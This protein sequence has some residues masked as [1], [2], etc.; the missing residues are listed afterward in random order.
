MEPPPGV[1][2]SAARDIREISGQ[3]SNIAKASAKRSNLHSLN[4]VLS[5]N[6]IVS[7]GESH[8]K[9]RNVS[10]LVKPKKDAQ[11]SAEATETK[12]DQSSLHLYAPEINLALS[13]ADLLSKT[14]SSGPSRLILQGRFGSMEDFIRTASDESRKSSAQFR[15]A[16]SPHVGSLVPT[17]D[18]AAAAIPANPSAKRQRKP[19]AAAAL[20]EK[21]KVPTMIYG[22]YS[23]AVLAL[24][25]PGPASGPTSE[26][27]TAA[28]TLQR[29][30]QKVSHGTRHLYREF[31][32]AR[33]PTQIYAEAIARVVEEADRTNLSATNKGVFPER[34]K[35]TWNYVQEVAYVEAKT[36]EE[37]CSFGS[38]CV[39]FD[40]VMHPE[41]GCFAFRKWIPPHSSR[42]HK[43]C[44]ACIV[45]LVAFSLLVH[46]AT[47]STSS[48][49]PKSYMPF[50]YACNV[51]GEYNEKAFMRDKDGVG[52][53]DRVRI[54]CTTDLMPAEK[55]ADGRRR[56]QE[57][58]VLRYFDGSRRLESLPLINPQSYLSF[59]AKTMSNDRMLMQWLFRDV[60][61][62]LRDVCK[63]EL[64]EW[65]KI[66]RLAFMPFEEALSVLVG[67][68]K[69]PVRPECVEFCRNS[70][71]SD[72]L[73]ERGYLYMYMDL[74]ERC[75]LDKDVV[76]MPVISEGYYVYFLLHIRVNAYMRMLTADG[77]ELLY[78]LILNGVPV[79]GASA[80][81]VDAK[82]RS[83]APLAPE[84]AVAAP[85]PID[86]KVPRP[87]AVSGGS[88]N[89]QRQTLLME[90]EAK[91]VQLETLVR[92]HGKMMNYICAQFSQKVPLVH[93]D[94][95]LSEDV[96]AKIKPS[97]EYIGPFFPEDTRFQE[98]TK[99]MSL[100]YQPGPAQRLAC[101]LRQWCI[102]LLTPGSPPSASARDAA[103]AI[104]DKLRLGE[105]I[106]AWTAEA[107]RDLAQTSALAMTLDVGCVRF[108]YELLFG[109]I[110]AAWW[111]IRS[112]D[113]SEQTLDTLMKACNNFVDTWD[114]GKRY[115]PKVLEAMRQGAS[116]WRKKY[117]LLVTLLL[118]IHCATALCLSLENI[119]TERKRFSSFLEAQ[120]DRRTELFEI[121]A[122]RMASMQS[123]YDY[124]FSPE[125]EALVKRTPALE[126]YRK[127]VTALEEAI[128]CLRR[129]INSHLPMAHAMVVNCTGKDG[130]GPLDSIL[131]DPTVPNCASVNDDR[132]ARP[133]LFELLIPENDN[134]MCEDNL[135]DCAAFEHQLKFIADSDVYEPI[136]AAQQKTAPVRCHT[137]DAAKQSSLMAA[138]NTAFL[139]YCITTLYCTM[140]GYRKST[141][142][143]QFDKSLELYHIFHEHVVSPGPP[144]SRPNYQA[145]LNECKQLSINAIRENTALN[146]SHSIGFYMAIKVC[147]AK[148]G[149]DYS[150]FER[151]WLPNCT[152]E[153]RRMFDQGASLQSIN[154]T[155]R[156]TQTRSRSFVYRRTRTDFFRF[157]WTLLKEV[158]CKRIVSEFMSGTEFEWPNILTMHRDYM[159][160]ILRIVNALD[161]HKD[162]FDYGP[163]LKEIGCSEANVEL[164]K[165][166]ELRFNNDQ[167][168][169]MATAEAAVSSLDE[170]QHL[171]VFAFFNVL[172]AHAAIRTIPLSDRVKEM[173]IEAVLNRS[174][175]SAPGS[176]F[177]AGMCLL[178]L[179]SVIGCH[180]RKTPTVQER[181]LRYLGNSDVSWDA[182]QE[183]PVCKPKKTA[184]GGSSKAARKQRKEKGIT[185]VIEIVEAE[186]ARK[187]TI[188]NSS[189][190][191][192]ANTSGAKS[193]QNKRKKTAGQ[194]NADSAEKG[195]NVSFIEEE[196][197]D[198][199]EE[200]G[201]VEAAAAAAAEDFFFGDGDESTHLQDAKSMKVALRSF[202]DE[203]YY[204]S[205]MLKGMINDGTIAAPSNGQVRF[206]ED[207]PKVRKLFDTLYKKRMD[208]QKAARK[209]ANALV[210]SMFDMP[211][212]DGV[213]TSH[214]M[215][216]NVV[217]RD[218]IKEKANGEAYTLCPCCG[219]VTFF[220]T[221]MIY[222]NGF[223]C[224]ECDSR[225]RE[226]L[227][228]PCCVACQRVYLTL[229]RERKIKKPKGAVNPNGDNASA[230]ATAPLI[231][232]VNKGVAHLPTSANTAAASGKGR[233][234]QNS[235]A[236]R[237][238]V[239]G[240]KKAKNRKSDEKHRAII[241]KPSCT[242]EEDM[243][244]RS[245]RTFKG[246]NVLEKLAS[247]EWYSYNLYDEEIA[248][249]RTV[250]VCG[251]CNYQR[252]FL[253]GLE[254]M[255][256]VG[257]FVK[258]ISMGIT[259]SQEAQRMCGVS[260][261]DVTMT[262]AN[263]SGASAPGDTETKAT[264]GSSHAS[265]TTPS[266]DPKSKP[267]KSKPR[268]RGATA[269]V[270]PIKSK[271]HQSVVSKSSLLT[272]EKA[273]S[274][275]ASSAGLTMEGKR[276]K[277]STVRSSIMKKL[278]NLGKNSE[279]LRPLD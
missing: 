56:Y 245:R 45:G 256:T 52:L 152:N 191:Y 235:G 41:G 54:F 154:A 161:P 224:A 102:E 225:L 206:P 205:E 16:Y 169:N 96:W 47:S 202:L 168:F 268:K 150:D 264:A 126:N 3:I 98:V 160:G 207:H 195:K 69:A 10:D 149:K 167:S 194:D 210:R 261:N 48:G 192:Q 227:L 269:M 22:R 78:G 34:I 2:S 274:Q 180:K 30:A 279:T 254:R 136:L 219:C 162:N 128:Y 232:V 215:L 177:P 176:E 204:V 130:D 61:G 111:W 28:Q 8:A 242:I 50:V 190:K 129:F 113:T 255:L 147:F 211:C 4:P 59:E 186:K 271:D 166:V 121:I 143:L 23:E 265:T 64:P 14:F 89:T 243:A 29:K 75:N 252:N 76:P 119:R 262:E 127:S 55:T 171:I 100:V 71:P 88:S 140:V 19:G 259:N 145:L 125:E 5:N 80:E 228:R 20:L 62:K 1:V 17:A 217:R 106:V 33:L 65:M 189:G 92:S 240:G 258:I 246:P 208:L 84:S 12:A 277:K 73:D 51:P 238:S 249:R 157:I 212:E 79:P 26:A 141:Y 272:S 175:S 214:C 122:L 83:A 77:L 198:E 221:D 105:S 151:H 183:A 182:S 95:L 257:D 275:A 234:A 170:C 185:A 90:F 94:A 40:I 131:L 124:E 42:K 15:A 6:E 213:I 231:M 39:G 273:V 27:A 266:A 181:G 87:H 229:D 218:F 267:M 134:V 81:E 223:T 36:D 216:G 251:A 146:I 276:R 193:R 103:L 132:T 135:P 179:C 165:Q 201:D 114:Y 32:N 260:A 163:T 53:T 173:Q 187:P 57:R 138:N 172:R 184:K 199:E 85:D 86:Q 108:D 63:R 244:M 247:D 72:F 18:T 116:V 37:A 156:E 241:V 24:Y 203:D 107:P 139:K 21:R 101:I 237:A 115:H 142:R 144:E 233:P 7:A 155:I 110:R 158:L 236:N 230:P 118:R 112:E 278:R 222:A 200:E 70:L 68:L 99:E 67:M 253:R 153:I 120:E 97:Q 209:E 66:M 174:C 60:A 188:T 220:R 164:I 197:D 239:A 196:D 31:N 263:V 148:S 35:L 9:A 104:V 43:F 137:R 270:A 226:D 93:D 13:D 123:V 82:I 159:R 74:Y 11:P 178:H 58:P 117:S 133:S 46:E 44:Y 25:S 38:L 49:P 91:K 248:E 109:D 250:Y